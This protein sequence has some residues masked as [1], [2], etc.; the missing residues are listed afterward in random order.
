MHTHKHSYVIETATCYVYKKYTI[1]PPRHVLHINVLNMIETHETI[2]TLY[3]CGSNAGQSCVFYFW[4]PR[5]CANNQKTKRKAYRSIRSRR[6]GFMLCLFLFVLV[7]CCFLEVSRIFF[8]K[9]STWQKKHETRN[10]HILFGSKM[11]LQG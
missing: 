4:F 10:T 11:F 2:N 1:F 6:L 7:L 9:A 3:T 5:G 8:A